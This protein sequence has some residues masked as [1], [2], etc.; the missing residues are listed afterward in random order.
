MLFTANLPKNFR[1]FVFTTAYINDA[2]PHASVENSIPYYFKHS[3]EPN[4]KNF[5]ISGS[6]DQEQIP[7]NKINVKMH[8]E[9]YLKAIPQ[10]VIITIFQKKAHHYV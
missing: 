9:R 3:S 8:K 6:D 5:K 10:W 7:D 1:E 4:L 2:L